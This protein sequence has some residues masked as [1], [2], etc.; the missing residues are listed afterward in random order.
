MVIS[1]VIHKNSA[2]FWLEAIMYKK[3]IL[4]CSISHPELVQL[5]LS[6]GDTGVSHISVVKIGLTNISLKCSG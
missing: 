1:F 6:P 4:G 5:S 2:G 3:S